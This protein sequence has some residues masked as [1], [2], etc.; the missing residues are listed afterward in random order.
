[1]SFTAYARLRLLQVAEA[2]T[3]LDFPDYFRV[4][5]SSAKLVGVVLMLAPAPA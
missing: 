4:E 3:H 1:M 5:L 2:S